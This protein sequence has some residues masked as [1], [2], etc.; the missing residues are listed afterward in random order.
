MGRHGPDPGGSPG[1]GP[2][3]TVSRG[4]QD[5]TGRRPGNYVCVPLLIRSRY[6]N[7]RM[8][9]LIFKE[10]GRGDYGDNAP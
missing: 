7:V 10:Y 2:A 4:N 9:N 3:V 5:F 1:D 6:I 8:N